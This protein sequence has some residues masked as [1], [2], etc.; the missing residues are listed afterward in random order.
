MSRGFNTKQDTMCSSKTRDK[1]KKASNRGGG[2]GGPKAEI[3]SVV[4]KS[5]LIHLEHFCY[6]KERNKFAKTRS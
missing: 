4:H 2:G 1:K 5:L 3:K 6:V